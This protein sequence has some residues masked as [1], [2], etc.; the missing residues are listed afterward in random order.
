MADKRNG[1]IISEPQWKLETMWMQVKRGVRS[2][3]AA[4]IGKQ[5]P[6]IQFMCRNTKCEYMGL[7]G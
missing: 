1:C 6:R 5:D 4:V 2:G 3:R 7:M